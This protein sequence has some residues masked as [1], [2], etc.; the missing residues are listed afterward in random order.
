MII[1][2]ALDRSLI[3]AGPS[4]SSAV[5]FPSP[6]LLDLPERAVQFGTGGFLRGFVEY[7]IDAANRQGGFG[8]RIVAISST[9]SGREDVL[10]RQNGLYT[11][12]VEG[13]ENGRATREF[14]LIS[15]LSRALSAV[16][17]W[18]EVL[19]VA[20]NP[21]IE[22]VFSNTTEIGI[23]LETD[24]A[25]ATPPRSFPGKLTVFLAERARAFDFAPD[26]GLI[27][28][29]C[30]LVERNGDRLRSIVLELA[31]RWMPAEP[32]GKWIEQNVV[33]CNTL[34]DRIV[35]GA[36]EE[37]RKG[38]LE[39][40]L[41]YRDALM[42]ACEPY[43]LFAIEQP[44]ESGDALRF[45]DSDRGVVIPEDIEPYVQ[46]K[47]R[48]LNG[49]HTLLAP[50]AIL[51]GFETVVESVSDP[52][53]G[54]Y[55]R[56]TMYDE[57]VRSLDVPGAGEFARQVVERFSNPYLAH[58]LFDITLQA[59]TKVRVRVLPSIVE[60]TRREGRAP[61][62]IAFAV[63]AHLLFLRGD[64]Q[65]RRRAAG[66][67]VPPDEAGLEVQGIWNRERSPSDVAWTAL[68]DTSLWGLDLTT[69]P[70]FAERVAGHL[71]TISE[72]GVRPA[73]EQVLFHP[74]HMSEGI[75]A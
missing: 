53:I 61:D 2:P 46:R 7:F 26:A 28:L 10:N 65:T 1:R 50:V 58:S 27:V 12:V 42:T 43:R 75:V 68:R 48:L 73:L 64:A 55:L 35:P 24:D 40:L 66:L 30:E 13:I 6:A 20:R 16:A 21:D 47:V 15:S 72:S 31:M 23:T 38:D 59:T 71:T 19:D 4:R 51:C 56:R 52:V 11:L 74:G 57:L 37:S 18:D 33:F 49:A 60:F 29:P 25:P 5:V 22:I 67:I 17:Q 8:G 45:A 39:D 62:L 14:H 63:A 70:G 54:A 44:P 34:V 9:E 41:G 69:V 3:T 32:V 36:P